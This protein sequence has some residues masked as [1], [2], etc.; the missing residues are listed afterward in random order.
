MIRNILLFTSFIMSIY[1]AAI[2]KPQKQAPAKQPDKNAKAVSKEDKQK[3]ELKSKLNSAIQDFKKYNLCPWPSSDKRDSATESGAYRMKDKDGNFSF[4][5]KLEDR[6]YP[7]YSE[8][9]RKTDTGMMKQTDNG[10]I[11]MKRWDPIYWSEKDR[12]WILY[13]PAMLD[14][15][16][17]R[18]KQETAIVFIGRFCPDNEFFKCGY[19]VGVLKNLGPSIK[20]DEKTKL[21][22]ELDAA[23]IKAA[24]SWGGGDLLLKIFKASIDMNAE[25]DPAKLISIV[26]E[27]QKLIESAAAILIKK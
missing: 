12:K 3:E 7:E 20:P 18:S 6:D 19:A 24:E 16:E 17:A 2:D 9:C 27:R 25:R 23:A 10:W 21:L 1:L 14:F 26:N 22:A 13:P 15:N 8:I 5:E 11:P 4:L